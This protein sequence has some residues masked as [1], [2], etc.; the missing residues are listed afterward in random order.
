MEDTDLGQAVDYWQ[1]CMFPAVHD[2]TGSESE[3]QMNGELFNFAVGFRALEEKI[4]TLVTKL[5]KL[6]RSDN[7]LSVGTA[8]IIPSATC[9]VPDW[10]TVSRKFYSGLIL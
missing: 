1:H 9:I 7:N 10:T 3:L 5:K 8:C 4:A 6:A 2:I